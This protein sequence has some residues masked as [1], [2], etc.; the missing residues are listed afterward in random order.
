MTAMPSS[1]GG[2]SRAGLAA[3]LGAGWLLLVA[4]AWIYARMTAIPAWA[5]IPVGAAFLIEIPFYLSPAFSPVRV[6]LASQGKVRT[7]CW[8]VLSSLVPW[9]V[10]SIPTGEAH[11]STFGMLLA[12][13]AVVAFWY[14]VLPVAPVTDALFLAAITAIYLSRIFLQI[15]ISPI[16]KLDISILGHLMLIRTAAFAILSI[17]GNVL[18][19]YRLIPNR[20][21]WLAGLQYFAFLLPVIAAA[22]WGLG[23]VQWRAHPR[24]PGITLLIAIGTFI[25]VLW[26]LALSEEFFFRGLLQ[27]WLERWT[28]SPAAGLIFASAIFGCAHLGFHRKFPNWQWAILAGILGIFCGL[29]WRKTRSVQSS[30]VTHALLVTVWRV[31]LQ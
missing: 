3:A 27:Q 8:L 11:L 4:A 13:V 7:A 28:N 10:Y 5:A 22:Y 24:G 19:E 25:G 15:Y 17:R 20:K 14:I 6:W 18:A 12:A 31:F 29:A 1:P 23:L 9:I 21:E 16:R 30:M 26:V 2:R